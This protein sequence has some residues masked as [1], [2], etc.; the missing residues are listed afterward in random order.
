MISLSDET[1]HTEE[2]SSPDSSVI[3]PVTIVRSG[4]LSRTTLVRIS[5]SDDTAQAGLDYKPKTETIKFA[6]GVSALDFDIEIFPDEEREGLE[7]FRVVLGPQDPVA[8]VYG[9]Y[10]SANVII[11][12]SSMQS[13]GAG[14]REKGERAIYIDS[15]VYFVDRN[16]SL[17]ARGSGSSGGGVPNGE[18]L[19]CL[20]VI[21][22]LFPFS[23]LWFFNFGICEFSKSHVIQKIRIIRQI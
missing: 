15:L 9:R 6:P 20:E 10:K 18:P 14:V 4:D 21:R 1:Y 13:G 3:K 23:N 17:T 2:P 11:R 8:G 16:G 19:V 5:T 7:S 22:V 12:D